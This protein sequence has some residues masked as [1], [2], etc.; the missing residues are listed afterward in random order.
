MTRKTNKALA[1]ALTA[2][3]LVSGAGVAL[4]GDPVADAHGYYLEKKHF[5]HASCDD[6]W[7]FRNQIFSEAGYCFKTD[8]AIQAFGNEGCVS[9]SYT[10][11]NTYERAN[12]TMLKSIE[13]AKGCSL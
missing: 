8:R 2:A 11:L 13:Q 4:A 12:V 3:A 5:K 10:I 6:L 9:G 1:A 7:H